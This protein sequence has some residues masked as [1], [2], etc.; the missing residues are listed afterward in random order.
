MGF[1]GRP[2]IEAR[3]NTPMNDMPAVI[4]HTSVLRRFTGMPSVAARSERSALARTA[5]P[6]SVRRR[7]NPSPTST[8]S[9]TSTDTTSSEWNS[10]VPTVNWRCHG[11]SMVLSP[12]ICWPQILGINN[13]PTRNSCEMPIVATVSTSR[14][15]LKKRRTNRNSTSAPK[16]TAATR[17]IANDNTHGNAHDD[18]MHPYANA[19][20]TVPRSA[21]AKLMTRF[22]R[23]TSARP[24]ATS[25]PNMPRTKP[26][27]HTP[28]GS[29]YTINWNTMTATAGPYGTSGASDETVGAGRC[30][31][32]AGGASGLIAVT[33]PDPDRRAGWTTS[34]EG[35]CRGAPVP[36]D[37]GRVRCAPRHTAADPTLTRG[38]SGGKRPRVAFGA[39]Q[40]HRSAGA[41]VDTFR[42]GQLRPL[43]FEGRQ[44]AS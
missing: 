24:S 37:R 30:A 22:A 12:M 15:D 6:I 39:G 7:N 10:S 41:G 27:S 36:L 23:C 43:R 13:A 42:G 40:A 21:C 25:E 17:P 26:S 20:G 32:A 19:V 3:K 8:A 9:T 14:D 11:N 4:A 44:V 16:I 28:A 38:S 1:S 33:R 31:R 2:R 18:V 29:G 34:R 5:M 35:S